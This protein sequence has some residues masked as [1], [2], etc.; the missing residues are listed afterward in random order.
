MAIQRL[1]GTRS[2]FDNPDQSS[3]TFYYFDA[4]KV[5]EVNGKLIEITTAGDFFDALGGADNVSLIT[6]RD[7]AADKWRSYL[8]DQSRE[9]SSDAAITDDR[10]IITVMKNAVTLR[11]KGDALGA[12]GM[13]AINLSPGLNLVGVPLKDARVQKVSDLLSLEG[14]RDN[15]SLIIVSDV[16]AFKVVARAGDDGDI[17]ITGGHSFIVNA[18]V[19]STIEITG[20]AWDNVSGVVASAPPMVLV[21]HTVDTETPVLAV[22]GALVDEVTGLPRDGFRVTVKNL[23]TRETLHTLSGSDSPE[24]EYSVTFVDFALRRAGRMGDMLEITVQTPSPLIG[25]Q[26]LRRIVSTDD[27]RTSQIRLP[28]LIAYEIPTETE[29]LANYPNPFNPETWIP[30]RL[31]EDALVTLTIFDMTGA[32]VRTIEVGHQPAAAYE[33]RDKAIYWDG[34]NAFGE[35]VASGI[36]FYRFTANGSSS[37][38]KMLIVK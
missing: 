12:D 32:V 8:G 3:G 9:T 28:A 10:G 27:V 26:R 30:Y 4:P 16:G 11:L 36:Y 1:E 25:I 20:E 18:S 5:T 13:S 35:R 6:T 14:I 31:A 19:A 24:G 17:A 33:S 2:G 37:T 23:S 7:I 21:G 29:L 15:A 22:Y 38:R 34:R